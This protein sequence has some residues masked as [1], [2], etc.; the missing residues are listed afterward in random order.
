MSQHWLL[1]TP[2]RA[3][4]SVLSD[5]EMPHD[6]LAC[7]LASSM[8]LKTSDGIFHG[9]EDVGWHGDAANVSAGCV[10]ASCRETELTSSEPRQTGEVLVNG[11]VAQL[12]SWQRVGRCTTPQDHRGHHHDHCRNVNFSASTLIISASAWLTAE[13]GLVQVSFKSSHSLLR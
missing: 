13:A 2:A 1:N 4:K 5:L 7:C 6:R 10:H 11:C 3:L 8:G 12:R 9:T